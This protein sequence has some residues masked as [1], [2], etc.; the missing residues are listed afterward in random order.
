MDRKT[1]EYLEERA[2]VARQI[3]SRIEALKKYTSQVAKIN[4]IYFSSLIDN[5]AIEESEPIIVE[6]VS[7]AFEKAV[8]EEI[9]RLEVELAEL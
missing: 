5:M 6:K 7:I 1:L 3:V 4:R 8:V 9:E 2:K